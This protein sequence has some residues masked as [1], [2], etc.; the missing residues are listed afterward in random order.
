MSMSGKLKIVFRSHQMGERGT[1]IALYDYALHNET[2]LQNE[3]FII[4]ERNNPRNV[5]EVIDKFE[6]RFPGRVFLY[7][8]DNIKEMNEILHK[9]NPDAL[10]NIKHGLIDGVMADSCKNLVHAVFDLR[11]PHGDVFATICDYMSRARG[12]GEILVVPHIVRIPS[13]EGDLREELGI[14]K[15]ATVLGRYGGTMTFNLREVY[16]IINSA[17]MLDENLYFV[18]MNTDKF[19]DDHPRIIHLPRAIDEERKFRFVNTCDGM[20]HAR[21]EGEIFSLALGEFS[22]SNKPVITWAGGIDRGHHE[23]L[24]DRMFVY[25]NEESLMEILLN[26]KQLE[27]EKNKNNEKDYWNVFKDK[28]SAEKVMEIFDRIFLS[29]CRSK[30]ITFNIDKSTDGIVHYNRSEYL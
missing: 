8:N 19:C 3:S 14:S 12:N 13:I 22:L 26:F 9:I 11:Q 30:P 25:D 21:I 6:N 15:D 20:I 24:G 27:K 28:F 5:Q 4:S 18:F 2:L 23:L 7:E 16:P 1:E 29:V 10:Y 17:V